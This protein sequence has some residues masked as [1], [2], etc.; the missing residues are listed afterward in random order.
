MVT[1]LE[2]GAKPNEVVTLS[3]D[4][5]ER[6]AACIACLGL[7]GQEGV[8][9]AGDQSYAQSGPSYD[10]TLSAAIDRLEKIGITEPASG[11]KSDANGSGSRSP[12][13]ESLEGTEWQDLLLASESRVPEHWKNEVL[14]CE[15]RLREAKISSRLTADLLRRRLWLY[16]RSRTGRVHGRTPWR[17]TVYGGSRLRPVRRALPM[18]LGLRRRWRTPD[19]RAVAEQR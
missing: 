6:R 3:S 15:C 9:R 7:G 2:N 4:E 10:A 8:F 12:A 17:V 18:L 13:S 11:T 14:K 1:A 5:P 16:L 19:S